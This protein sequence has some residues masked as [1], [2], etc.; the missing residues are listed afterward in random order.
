MDQKKIWSYFQNKNNKVFESS[1]Y[2][3]K[4]LLKNFKKGDKVLNIGVGNGFFEKLALEKKIDIYSLDPDQEIIRKISKLI[5]RKAKVG[6]S[7]NIPF[8]DNF[9][10]GVVMSEVLEHLEAEE[11]IR[12]IDEVWRVLK[13]KGVFIGTVPYNENLDEQVVVCPKC[14]NLFHKWGHL[15]SFNEEKIMSLLSK[16]FEI[17]IIKPKMFIS[18]NTLNYKGK[19]EACFSYLFYILNLKRSGLNLYFKAKKK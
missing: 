10:D 11:I 7:S 6:Y 3:L 12:T 17:N 5:G 4:Y 16:K 8:Q 19:I 9:F 15:Q 18:W 2:R 14:G 13:F 1:K